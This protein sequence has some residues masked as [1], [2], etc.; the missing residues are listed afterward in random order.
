MIK[1]N[2][3]KMMGSYRIPKLKDSDGDG[4]VLGIGNGLGLNEING[5]IAIVG[6]T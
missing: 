6:D 1:P 4:I 5:P 3:K 2:M